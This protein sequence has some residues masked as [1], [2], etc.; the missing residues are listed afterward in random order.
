MTA[1]RSYTKKE[2]VLKFEGGFHGTSDY[3]LM[4]VTPSA[5]EEFPQAEANSAGIPKAIQDL[6]LIAPFNDL[7]T[8]SAIIDAHHEE[9]AAVIA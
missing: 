1:A 4:S 8:T 9:M 3:A 5:A 2:K 7:D 6:M